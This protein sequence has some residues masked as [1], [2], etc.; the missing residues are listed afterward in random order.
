MSEDVVA[1]QEH[2]RDG[3]KES[4]LERRHCASASLFECRGDGAMSTLH[5]RARM[6]LM[7]LGEDRGLRRYRGGKRLVEHDYSYRRTAQS[8][9]RVGQ[10]SRHMQD[11]IVDTASGDR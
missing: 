7:Y 3:E 5:V 9:R 10:D 2:K 4:R 6:R 11:S 1:C 8:S